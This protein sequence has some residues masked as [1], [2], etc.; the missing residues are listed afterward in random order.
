MSKNKKIFFAVYGLILSAALA[1]V[2]TR[3]GVFEIP[4]FVDAPAFEWSKG[5]AGKIHQYRVNTQRTGLNPVKFEAKN[6]TPRLLVPDFNMDVHTASKSSPIGD[7]E[8]LYIGS[9]SGW[10]YGLDSSGKELWSFYYPHSN[11]GFHATAAVDGDMVIVGTYHGYVLNFNKDTGKLNWAKK[12]SNAIGSSVLL[13]GSNLYVTAEFTSPTDGFLVKLDALSGKTIWTSA[14]VGEHPHSSP[15]LSE[16]GKLVIFGANNGFVYAMDAQTGKQ[17]WKTY[18]GRAIKGTAMIVDQKVVFASWSSKIFALDQTTGTLLWQTTIGGASQSSA[19]L[20]APKD[21]VMV[22]SGYPGIFVVSL[23]QGKLL[24]QYPW[25]GNRTNAQKPSGVAF[26][27]SAWIACGEKE[28][29][30]FNADGSKLLKRIP[31]QGTVTGE[32]YFQNDHLYFATEKG[33][34]LYQL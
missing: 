22:S 17:V 1:W 27:N 2:D 25:T 29:C 26:K 11:R 28:I 31:I 32:P 16:D 9:D 23:N 3:E 15:V 10:F 13:D 5:N 6:P 24:Y 14:R 7:N 21:R 30:E 8:N 20:L 34:G 33:G 12:V 18:T 4:S 19:T